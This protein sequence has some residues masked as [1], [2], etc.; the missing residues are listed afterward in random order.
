MSSEDKPKKKLPTFKEYWEAKGAEQGLQETDWLPAWM[1]SN[2]LKKGAIKALKM[3]AKPVKDAFKKSIVKKAATK[4]TKPRK[5]TEEYHEELAQ[6]MKLERQ[7]AKDAMDRPE[8]IL[9]YGEK[10]RLGNQTPTLR[11]YGK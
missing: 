10:D 7:K 9:S 3:T 1:P 8:H 6:K 5:T 11:K 4:K 2:L